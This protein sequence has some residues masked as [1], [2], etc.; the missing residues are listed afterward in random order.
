ML[1]SFIQFSLINKKQNESREIQFHYC[2]IILKRSENM[3]NCE[4]LLSCSDKRCALML[5]NKR[6][7]P[8]AQ[9]VLLVTVTA[10]RASERQITSKHS[11]KTQNKHMIKNNKKYL[12][13]QNFDGEKNSAV[14]RAEATSL[15]AVFFFLR[16]GPKMLQLPAEPTTE[17]KTATFSAVIL[18]QKKLQFVLCMYIYSP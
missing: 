8:T 17:K 9:S 3:Q 2:F 7:F 18:S 11:R 13:S 15:P 16:G 4:T 12:H 14:S 1:I 10:W 5:N 6:V